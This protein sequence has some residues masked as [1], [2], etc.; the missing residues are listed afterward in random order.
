M[1]T[2]NDPRRIPLKESEKPDTNA[3][4]IRKIRLVDGTGRSPLDNAAVLIVNNHIAAAGVDNEIEIPPGARVLDGKGGTLL[5]GMIDLHTHL[6]YHETPIEAYT[7]TEAGATVRAISKLGF[8][9]NSGITSIR[10]LASRGSVAFAL[11]EGVKRGELMGPRIFPAGQFITSIGGHG[12]EKKAFGAALSFHGE[13]RCANGPDDFRLAVREQIKNGATYIKLG[14]NFTRQEVTAAVD[15]AHQ[16]CIRVT[17]DAHTHYIRWAVEAGIDCIEHPLPRTQ[18]TIELMREKGTYAVPTLYPYIRIFDQ[19]GGFYGSMSRRFY[20]SKDENLAVLKRLKDAE[21]TM[22][23]GTDLVY[24][25]YRDLPEPYLTELR[26]FL[27]VGFSPMEVL[28]AA[29]RNGAEI[30]GMADKLG[31]IE[32]GKLADLIVIDG[33]PI[34]DLESLPRIRYVVV[35]GRVLVSNEY[36]G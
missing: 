21:I 36:E 24:D 2:T 7:D 33:D 4:V 18:E 29:T 27:S 28:Q 10:D 26:Q 6:A 11:S 31:T 30:L 3:L 17:A 22:G 14:S 12:D 13:I 25:W 16:F 32:P 8:Y 19:S 35:D 23:I 5:P 9:L 1:K 20:F 34:E 15:E